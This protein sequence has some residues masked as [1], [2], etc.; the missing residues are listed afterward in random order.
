MKLK[1]NLVKKLRKQEAC[2]KLWSLKRSHWIRGRRR[3]R[4]WIGRSLMDRDKS[5]HLTSK[6]RVSKDQLSSRKNNSVKKLR[7][8]MKPLHQ[9]KKPERCGLWDLR[10]SRVNIHKQIPNYCKRRVISRTKSWRPKTPRFNLQPST[11]RLIF[12]QNKTRNSKIKSMRV[13][14]SRR[15]L[16]VS[17]ILKRK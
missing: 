10:R 16:N 3:L 1:S 7:T 2:K 4:N 13:R 15:I 6:S 9:R 8:W 11:D 14:H 12:S 5:I 17:W